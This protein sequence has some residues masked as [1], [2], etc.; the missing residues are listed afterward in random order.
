MRPKSLRTRTSTGMSSA[1][2]TDGPKYPVDCEPL[3]RIFD[4]P[5]APHEEHVISFLNSLKPHMVDLVQG[6]LT[7]PTWSPAENIKS[8][9]DDRIK[10]HLEQLKLPCIRGKPSVLLHG[11]GQF[12]DDPELQERVNDVFR[13]ASPINTMFINTS[14]SGK[15]RILLEGLCQH[16]G[17]YFTAHVDPSHL[18]SVDLQNAI[19]ATIPNDSQFCPILPST[20]EYHEKLESNQKLAGRVFTRVFLARTLIFCL[21][22]D[23][24]TTSSSSEKVSTER[25]HHRDYRC[26]WLHIQLQPSIVP[27]YDPFDDL[28]HKLSAYSDTQLH[29]MTK[30]ALRS[31]RESL[32]S[33]TTSASSSNLIPL[34]CVIDEAQVAAT[35]HTKAFCSADDVTP[36]G[37]A[38]P[39]SVLRPLFHT[40][41][42]L[43]PGLDVPII[44]SGM[45]LSQSDVDAT[46]T[47]GIMKP[48]PKRVY[49]DTGAFEGWDGKNG[50]SNWVKLFVP[51]W[52]LD[53]SDRKRLE[54][55]MGYWLKGRYR[56]V[57]GYVTELLLHGYRYPNLLLNEYIHQCTE[58]TPTDDH[59]AVLKEERRGGSSK[60]INIEP[61][62]SWNFEKFEKNSKR[63]LEID[64]FFPLFVMRSIYLGTLG[65][66]DLLWVENGF[67]R[68][69]KVPDKGV[70][71][72]EPLVVAA[73]NHWFSEKRYTFPYFRRNIW[74]NDP[75][76]TTNGFENFITY[77]LAR[78]FGVEDGQ[79]L[80]HVFQFHG[81]EP[82]WADK[83]ASLVSVCVSA[84]GNKPQVN[85]VRFTE[86]S[87]PSPMLGT[88]AKT[89]EETLQWLGH[90]SRTAFCFPCR[91]M[92]PDII[93]V[94]KLRNGRLLWVVLQ[95][96]YCGQNELLDKSTLDDA[97]KSVTPEHFF[98]NKNGKDNPPSGNFNQKTLKLLEKL[99]NR[100]NRSDSGPYS[101][102]RVVASSPARPEFGEKNNSSENWQGGD[103]HHPIATLKMK[104]IEQETEKWCRSN[105]RK[106]E[107]H[108][109]NGRDP[110][111]MRDSDT[112]ESNKSVEKRRKMMETEQDSDA[113][114][115]SGRKS[116]EGEDSDASK[117]SGRN[118][119]EGEDSDA[120]VSSK[121]SADSQK[122][123][124]D[125]DGAESSGERGKRRKTLD[126][127]DTKQA[128]GAE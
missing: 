82:K 79:K 75:K 49:H 45:G 103:P 87:G 116:L 89:Q 60:D 41:L 13:P 110:K 65:D 26:K 120:S 47:S 59:E 100:C 113:S 30:K 69:R 42:V 72:D 18:G 80:K 56:F 99:P 52:I 63:L 20:S 3:A 117:S 2:G 119:L 34:Y 6:C 66:N 31:I 57:A 109:S 21:F 127:E 10:T 122:R 101:L 24:M 43:T 27:M 9:L 83:R 5:Q 90:H 29:D 12:A 15:T 107:L 25:D 93:F 35:E 22:M 112:T 108:K 16:W 51:D 64:G 8:P 126:V 67:A 128:V 106:N 115:S 97:I 88:Y 92:R 125:A 39:R 54:D 74:T 37:I 40:V 36:G 11:L 17:F 91:E 105:I 28:T 96:K 14:G 33:C 94:L 4:N 73:A 121:K 50:M 62:S 114:E 76:G 1:S 32:R 86:Y 61:M 58:F 81:T 84:T 19:Q 104:F 95:A 124:R 46:V 44:L 102:L 68:L 77:C 78:I 98:R 23:A 53:E 70:V 38:E 85:D 111:R 48:S 55:R 123:E 7:L 71:F 118:S